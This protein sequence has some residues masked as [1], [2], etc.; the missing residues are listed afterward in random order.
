MENFDL[1]RDIAERTN[2]DI[3][4]GVVGPVRA[5]KSTFITKF[6]EA[7]VLPNISNVHKKERAVDELP[8]SAAGKTIMTT[9][10]KFVPSEGVKIM[11]R[12]KVE[13]KIRLCD[14]VGYMIE[15]A[16]GHKEDGKNR[17][18][19]TP[20]SDTEIPFEQA[21]ELGTK[22]VIAEHSTVG[23]VLTSDGTINTDIPRNSYIAA[24]ERVVKEL[25]ALGKPFIVVL[26]S[27][28]PSSSDTASL[29]EA[30]NEKYDV[31]VLALDVLKM[32]AEDVN[33]ILEKALFEF[34][35]RLIEVALPKWMQTL[36]YE[37]RLIR[38][39]ADRTRGLAEGIGKM[40]QFN[41][42]E[43][44]FIESEDIKAGRV[45]NVSMG[46]GRITFA[47]EPQEGL[48]YRTLSE[49]CG[50]EIAGDY[51][52]ISFVKQATRAK[53]EYDKLKSALDEVKE[54]GYGV[55]SPTMD[56]MSLED[57]EIVRQGNRFG[58][59][60]KAS[61]PSL[62]IMRVDIETEVNPIVG[63]EQ[64]SEEM[65]KY[66]LSEFESNPKGIWETNM[67]GKSLHN[68]V[69]ENLSNKLQSMPVDA[70]KKMR[71]T[72]TRIVNEGRGGVICILL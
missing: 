40:R 6:M 67:F 9:Q 22:K 51:Q 17:L 47:I 26:N 2:G 56:D 15:G 19:K 54:S 10:P 58:V 16:K 60:L 46:E 4:V 69:K 71:R 31:P 25:K 1:Y 68:L 8:Q 39:L 63:T 41:E 53:T 48:F 57:P 49:E 11:I 3:Y 33:D 38:E 12:D 65:V 59:R 34:P 24:E 27:A 29:R 28:A 36:P 7:L 52:L 30:L 70:Q 43:R 20:W 5:G 37:H 55:V 64:Q 50:T 61:A 14:C 44:F 42:A 72:L 23:V 32:N 62:H 18:V 45:E 13:V 35:V 21:A 66:M